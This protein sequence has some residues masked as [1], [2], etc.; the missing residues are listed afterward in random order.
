MNPPETTPLDTLGDLSSIP[1]T[2]RI[3]A[4]DPGGVRTGLAL[5]DPLQSIASPLEV[6]IAKKRGALAK[7]IAQ[8]A[9]QLE[10]VG[11]LVGLPCSIRGEIGPMARGV[12]KLVRAIQSQ[13][14]CPVCTLDE[15]YT[16]RDANEVFVEAGIRASDRRGKVDKVAAA[17]LLQR[18]LD[19][20]PSGPSTS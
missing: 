1:S 4:V 10:A 13:T 14:T 16:S 7:E 11:I 18:F 8:K 15:S 19:L 9:E 3:L 20:R 5:S 17:L 6:W 2:G 12:L